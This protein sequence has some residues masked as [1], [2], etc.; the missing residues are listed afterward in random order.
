VKIFTLQQLPSF[1]RG[2]SSPR[3]GEGEGSS[4]KVCA[5]LMD[6]WDAS[7]AKANTELVLSPTPIWFQSGPRGIQFFS[8]ID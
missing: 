7:M 4:S 2:V 5:A 3:V 8:A 6:G 1:E